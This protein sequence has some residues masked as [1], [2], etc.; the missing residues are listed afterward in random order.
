MALTTAVLSP[1]A[2]QNVR[3]P[4][5]HILSKRQLVEP[6]GT[7]V[8]HGSGEKSAGASKAHYLTMMQ[9]RAS[10][11]SGAGG[12]LAIAATIATR[13]SCVR[14]QGFVDTAQDIPYQ[15]VPPI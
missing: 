7:Y 6:D 10:M 3:I 1:C 14:R 2:P 15:C 12:K 13:Y 4:R 11:V 9:A 5:Q 8:R